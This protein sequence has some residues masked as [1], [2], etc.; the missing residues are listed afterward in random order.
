MLALQNDKQEHCHG[1][2]SFTLV[3]SR[4]RSTV[5]LSQKSALTEGIK[6]E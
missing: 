2:K 4:I 1:I 3:F 5:I 6:S